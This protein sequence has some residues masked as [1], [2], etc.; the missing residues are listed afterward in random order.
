MDEQ[1]GNPIDKAIG[2]AAPPVEMA[3]EG[4]DYARPATVTASTETFGKRSRAA[5]SR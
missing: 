4:L 5:Q 1:D 2:A 3:V